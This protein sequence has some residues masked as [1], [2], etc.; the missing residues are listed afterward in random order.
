MKKLT[1]LVSIVLIA[2]LLAVGL[3][4]C[5]GN[6]PLTKKVYDWNGSIN[7]KYVQQIAFW[8]MNIVPVYGAATF[9]DVVLLNTIEFWTGTNPLALNEN[10]QQIRYTQ[11]GNKTFQYKFSQNKVVI[12]ETAGP[13]AGQQV[14]VV[15]NPETGSWYLTSGGQQ[16][17]IASLSGDQLSLI[18]PNGQEQQ[19]NLVK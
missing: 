2:I 13:D 12:T 4:G 15:F 11:N 8:V 9:I 3:F 19:V 5:Y 10:E 17:K 16:H 14:E 1:R 18:Y 7:D 6:M